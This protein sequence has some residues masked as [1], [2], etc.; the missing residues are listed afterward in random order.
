MRR[1]DDVVELED[2]LVGGA[3]L[4]LE[5]V[6]PGAGDRAVDQGA[7][8]RPLVDHR[9]ARGVDDVGRGLHQPQQALAHDVVRGLAQRHADREEV[10]AA[11]QLLQ[12]DQLDAELG[13]DLRVLVGVV[14]E[15]AHAERC[16][17]AEHLGADIAHA[18][19]AQRLADQALAH[20]VGPLG[21]ARPAPGGRA[22][23]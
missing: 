15:E 12:P 10:G 11:E 3:R 17:E 5:H 23:P 2:R 14:G 8:Q 6:E 20:V 18:E 4:D 19:L 9:P 13:R 22:G 16:R 21:P 1:H 7:V